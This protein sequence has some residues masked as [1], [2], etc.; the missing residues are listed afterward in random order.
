M[1]IV[2]RQQTDQVRRVPLHQLSTVCT[3]K[4]RC[5][6]LNL[7]LHGSSPE[8]GGSDHR[9]SPALLRA[10]LAVVELLLLLAISSSGC[11][12]MQGLMKR[13]GYVCEGPDTSSTIGSHGCL[14]QGLLELLTPMLL[15]FC[16]VVVLPR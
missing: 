4:L 8:P 16:F 13:V 15:L 14:G 12:C 6:L 9:L 1:G 7:L 10:G 3:S 5:K 2:D 11:C